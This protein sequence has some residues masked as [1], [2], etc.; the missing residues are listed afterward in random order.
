M[1]T[2]KLMVLNMS[3]VPRTANPSDVC[4]QNSSSLSSA[5]NGSSSVTSDSECFE[6]GIVSVF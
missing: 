3:I 2:G 6:G 1:A 4:L 5:T